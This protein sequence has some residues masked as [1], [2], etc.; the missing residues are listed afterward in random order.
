MYQTKNDDNK[1]CKKHTRITLPTIAS[2]KGT[3]IVGNTIYSLFYDEKCT[4]Y[5]EEFIFYDVKSIFLDVKY[6]I[7]IVLQ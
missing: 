2:A 6:R 5:D 1:S 7:S 4:F 3:E